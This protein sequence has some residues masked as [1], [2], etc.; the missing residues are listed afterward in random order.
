MAIWFSLNL[1]VYDTLFRTTAICDTR[2]SP[3]MT[4]LVVPNER[5]LEMPTKFFFSFQLQRAK[6]SWDETGEHK[7]E[8]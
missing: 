7:D 8:L 6:S 2:T 1:G 4:L 5:K 3:T